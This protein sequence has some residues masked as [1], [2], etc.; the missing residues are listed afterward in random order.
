MTICDKLHKWANARKSYDWCFDPKA[1]PVNGIYIIFEK[2]ES[3]HGANRIVRI[4][5]HNG[6]KQL[7]PRLRQHFIQANKDRS[8]FRKN[9]GRAILHR[10]SDPFASDWEIDLT[11]KSAREEHL[12]RIDMALIRICL[13]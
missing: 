1:L 11:A 8:I 10:T 12:E 6:D 13:M 2:G 3:G 9:I 7:R 4:G 5:T